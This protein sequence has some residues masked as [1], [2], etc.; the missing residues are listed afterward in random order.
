MLFSQELNNNHFPKHHSQN[1]QRPKFYSNDIR[2]KKPLVS[3]TFDLVI[4]EV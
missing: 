4:Q 2:V 1:H 3:I